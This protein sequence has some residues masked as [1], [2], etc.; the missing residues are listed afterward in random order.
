MKAFS[1]WRRLYAP[2]IFCLALPAAGSAWAASGLAWRLETPP[3]WVST[4]Q[5]PPDRKSV[6]LADPIYP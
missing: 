5:L 6:A 3:S 4:Y 2:L 1:A